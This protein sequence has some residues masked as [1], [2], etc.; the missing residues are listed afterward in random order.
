MK[1]RD[2]NQCIYSD[3]KNLLKEKI[4]I[5]YSD[6]SN[7]M[8]TTGV[9]LIVFGAVLLINGY[10]KS[11]IY[12]IN[13]GIGLIVIGWILF[14]FR[15]D[16]YIEYDITSNIFNDY[17]DLIKKLIKQW[18]IKTGGIIIPPRKNLKNGCIYLSF[19]GNFKVNLRKVDNNTLFVN[20]GKKKIGLLLSPLGKGIKNL[21]KEY[22]G[23]FII[24]SEDRDINDLLEE[25]EYLLTLLQV[26][27]DVRV[28]MKK[29]IITISYRIEDNS[30]CKKLQKEDLCRKYP[31]PVCGA[32]L[33][34]VAEFLNKMLKIES[35]RE[36]NKRVTIKLKVMKMW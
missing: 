36:R 9:I 35:I 22:R 19:S 24:P 7:T 13:L 8:K 5:V 29:D 21:L 2:I 12:F 18:D 32:M 30:L 3:I 10:L 11:I 27:G 34:V 25:L 6:I 28:E 14:I 15:Y 1:K 4:G 23:D 33:L 20:S 31:C 26:G 16:K 17:I